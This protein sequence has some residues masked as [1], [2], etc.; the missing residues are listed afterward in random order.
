LLNNLEKLD[1]GT[2]L[3]TLVFEEPPR[4]GFAGFVV[5]TDRASAFLQKPAT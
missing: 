5:R 4:V 2:S 3:G 1:E